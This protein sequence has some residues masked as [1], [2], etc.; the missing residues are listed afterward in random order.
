M[1]QDRRINDDDDKLVLDEGG[2]PRRTDELTAENMHIAGMASRVISAAHASKRLFSIDQ[3][4]TGIRFYNSQMDEE[5]DTV[6]SIK[7][8]QSPGTIEVD[9]NKD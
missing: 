3:P 1:P 8:G 2:I 4:L 9:V 6:I 7:K 5:P